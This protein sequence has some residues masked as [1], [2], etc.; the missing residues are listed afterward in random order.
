[1]WQLVTAVAGV[2]LPCTLVCSWYACSSFY[3]LN[4]PHSCLPSQP[5]LSLLITRHAL[6][7]AHQVNGA[8]L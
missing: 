2:L 5:Q 8:V 3:V 1:M 4:Q 7:L 6:F